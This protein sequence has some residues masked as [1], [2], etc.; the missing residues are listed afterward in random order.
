MDR[1]A[2]ISGIALGLP[3]APLAAEARG[4]TKIPHVGFLSPSS[5][6]DPRTAR[7]FQAFRQGLRDAGYVESQSIVI[8]SRWAEGKY[9]YRSLTDD[10]RDN[11]HSRSV[12]S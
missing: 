3:A 1:R 6:F 7:Y 12:A 4:P 5:V 2:F 10:L 11:P 9:R 8:E